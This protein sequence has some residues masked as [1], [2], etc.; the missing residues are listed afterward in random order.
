MKLEGTMQA[1]LNRLLPGSLYPCV[2]LSVGTEVILVNTI[3]PISAY[4][5]VPEQQP[6]L[7]WSWDVS[8]RAACIKV[9]NSLLYRENVHIF[10]CRY[11]TV[12]H[13]HIEKQNQK[14]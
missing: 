8:R 4:Q 14:E 2:N 6:L 5:K 11:L 1:T 7:L 13:L 10:V 9:H 3:I 12:A